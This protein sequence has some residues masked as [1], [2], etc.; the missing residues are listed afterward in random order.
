MKNPET[1]MINRLKMEKPYLLIAGDAYYPSAGTGDWVGF[2]ETQQE[3]KS[4]IHTE[5]VEEL[6]KS[7][8]RRGQV[9]ETREITSINGRKCDWYEIVDVELESKLLE[10]S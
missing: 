10:R 2:F 3:A 8:P 5:T 6:F 7:G 1:F 4:Q 9:K